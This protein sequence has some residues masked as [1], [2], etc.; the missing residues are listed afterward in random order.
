MI[1]YKPVKKSTFLEAVAACIQHEK[2]VFEFYTRQAE[3]L[4]EGP[5]KNLFYKLAE[6]QDE[7]IQMISNLYSEIKGGE[8]LPN[9]K[10]ASEVQKFNS[11][12]IQIFMRRLDRVTYKDAKG[13]ELEALALATQQLEDAADFYNKMAD[14]FEDPNIRILFKQLANI[15]EEERLL[16]E[17]FSAYI[18]QGSPQ[19]NPEAYWDLSES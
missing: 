19:S 11:T 3:S 17:S 4:P 9:L 10:L 12:S 15:K 2:N 16:M 8:A 18:S 7:Q 14:K 1:K 13:Q 5:I 6:D